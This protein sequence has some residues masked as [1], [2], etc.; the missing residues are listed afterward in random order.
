MN[1]IRYEVGFRVKL[2]KPTLTTLPLAPRKNYV[3][4]PVIVKYFALPSV[5]FFL[6][7]VLDGWRKPLAEASGITGYEEVPKAAYRKDSCTETASRKS[8]QFH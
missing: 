6:T 1:L 4:H 8:R 5:P 2:A 7:L 3:R